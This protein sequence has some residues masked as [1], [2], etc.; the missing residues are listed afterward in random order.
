LVLAVDVAAPE[1]EFDGSVAEIEL[2]AVI[3]A[4]GFGGRNTQ[5]KSV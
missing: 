2:Q 5:S 3:S 1:H 4:R